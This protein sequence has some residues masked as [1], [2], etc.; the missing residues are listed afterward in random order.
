MSPNFKIIKL[1]R[2]C[3]QIWI[4]CE[5]LRLYHALNVSGDN[6]FLL[7]YRTLKVHIYLTKSHFRSKK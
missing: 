6:G 2:L 4:F 5:V 7:L 1:L 3:S